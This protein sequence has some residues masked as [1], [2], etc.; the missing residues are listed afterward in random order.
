MADDPVEA[1]HQEVHDLREKS[2]DLKGLLIAARALDAAA[3]EVTG[4][5]AGDLTVAAP[6]DDDTDDVLD[7]D[8]LAAEATPAAELGAE[9]TG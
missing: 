3:A 1:L 8:E 9:D 2:E 7:L 5:G 6:A 4:P